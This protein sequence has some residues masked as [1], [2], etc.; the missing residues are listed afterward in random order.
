MDLGDVRREYESLRIGKQDLDD[1]PILQFGQWLRQARD[2][3]LLDATAMTLATASPDGRP[4][5]RIVL[6][7]HFD[8]D[9]FCWYTDSRSRKGQELR[10]NPRAALLFHWRDFSRQI[11][12]HGQVSQLPPGDAENY[13]QSRPE[14]SRFSAAASHQSAEIPSR[15]ALEDEVER[16][17]AAHPDGRVPRPE[18]WLGYRLAPEY[19]EF[20]QGQDSRLHDRIVYTPAADGWIKRRLA[21]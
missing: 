1:D 15:V 14:G 18:A 6:L 17:R 11:R 16:L 4:S 7:K 9:G 19:F 12:V 21:P 2:H 5:A 13:F 10:D 8:R 20:W 3:E